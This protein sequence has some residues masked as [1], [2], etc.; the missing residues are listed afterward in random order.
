MVFPEALIRQTATAVTPGHVAYMGVHRPVVQVFKQSGLLDEI[1]PDLLIKNRGDA[2]TVLFDKI[3]HDYCKNVCP[4]ALFY[5]C[6]S[7][8]KTP[9][10]RVP[11]DGGQ[12]TEPQRTE[13]QM[14]ETVTSKE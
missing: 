5:E 8:K 10:D 6:K 4:Y 9:A 14:P 11:E 1:A 7:V 3:D 2:I 12:R 13:P